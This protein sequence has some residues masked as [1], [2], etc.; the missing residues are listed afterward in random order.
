MESV[1]RIL[2]VR[3]IH[4]SCL[5][6]SALHVFTLAPSLRIFMQIA[7]FSFS[8]CL[9]ST[10]NYS[11]MIFLR[12]VQ[13]TCWS[14]IIFEH[15]IETTIIFMVS[16]SG[17]SYPIWLSRLLFALDISWEDKR[18]LPYDAFETTPVLFLSLPMKSL[19]FS[20]MYFFR[21]DSDFTHLLKVLESITTIYLV[22]SF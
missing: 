22:I 13:I 3:S 15:A 19:S 9:Y 20:E 4:A 14:V 16:F 5:T 6:R 11:L 21:L 7:V 1:I 8:V 17:E 2:L 12:L 18:S 10:S